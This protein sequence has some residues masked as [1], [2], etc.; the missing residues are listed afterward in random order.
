VPQ[1]DRSGVPGVSAVPQL[2]DTTDA[3][4]AASGPS[5]SGAGAEPGPTR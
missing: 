2:P 4:E 5:R 3:P 1:P